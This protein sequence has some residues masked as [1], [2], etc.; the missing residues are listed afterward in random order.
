MLSE[1]DLI[2]FLTASLALIVLPG[3]DNT[4]VLTRSVARG[5]GAALVSAAARLSTLLAQA[6]NAFSVVKYAEAACLIS[7][8]DQDVSGQ[9]GLRRTDRSGACKPQ[10]RLR[11]GRGLERGQP[12]GGAV[13]FGTSAAVR[14]AAPPGLYGSANC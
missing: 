13:L 1:L 6:A 4:L 2:L 14:R 8:G 12:E 7:L 10:E 5:R 9:G 3:P 11:S